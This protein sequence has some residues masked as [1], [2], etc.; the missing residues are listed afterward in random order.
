MHARHPQ[1]VEFE[2]FMM[3]SG[4]YGDTC[5][6]ELVGKDHQWKWKHQKMFVLDQKEGHFCL[7]C[8]EKETRQVV[9][10]DGTEKD[11]GKN[12]IAEKAAEDIELFW[13]KNAKE[14]LELFGEL[15]KPKQLLYTLHSNTEQ[16]TELVEKQSEQNWSVLSVTRRYP[17]DWSER[18]IVQNDGCRSG[19]IAL[20]HLLMVLGETVEEEFQTFLQRIDF[21]TLCKK[22]VRD[23]T[24]K[25]D[26]PKDF[27]VWYDP[28]QQG[29][30]L[31]PVTY[32]EVTSSYGRKAQGFPAGKMPSHLRDEGRGLF[33]K[34]RKEHKC[35]TA[36]S[37]DKSDMEE[38]DAEDGPT[39]TKI[40]E[41][42]TETPEYN[43]LIKNLTR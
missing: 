11:E 37:G 39:L 12:K 16:T 22:W 20:M 26:L 25:G 8:F 40:G 36:L 5:Y 28:L 9:I 23:C 21:G 18:L 17:E 10:W 42:Y 35:L 34:A 4:I 24:K 2:F 33:G 27:N 14:L 38:S 43:S 15:P 1:N 7:M 13:H 6:K 3:V 41:W 32:R 29:V 31:Q 19:A 30:T